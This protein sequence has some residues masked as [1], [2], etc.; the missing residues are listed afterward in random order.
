MASEELRSRTDSLLEQKALQ[1]QN[2]DSSSIVCL[3]V[4]VSRISR[5]MRLHGGAR[6][7]ERGDKEL[8][9]NI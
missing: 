4:Y 2:T 8:L 3:S 5:K 1:F 9:W 6:N 7:T